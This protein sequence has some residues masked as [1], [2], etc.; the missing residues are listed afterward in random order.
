MHGVARFS[1]P[2]PPGDTLNGTRHILAL[3]SDGTH[4]AYAANNQLYLRAMDQME[5][6]PVRGTEGALGPFFSP[7]VVKTNADQTF[8]G[9]VTGFA[10]TDLDELG[11]LRIGSPIRFQDRHIFRCAA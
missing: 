9:K 7:E 10:G 2:L 11:D 4:L 6:T 8:E 1:L 3:S 5:A